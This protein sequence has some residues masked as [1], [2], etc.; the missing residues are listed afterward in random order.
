[1]R[2]SVVWHRVARSPT[3]RRDGE[4]QDLDVRGAVTLADHR[5][6][7]VVEKDPTGD[8]SI[9]VARRGVRADAVTVVGVEHVQRPTVVRHRH[10]QAEDVGHGVGV[11][12]ADRQEARPGGKRKGHPGPQIPG[13]QAVAVARTQPVYPGI[14]SPD[15]HGSVV[16]ERWTR[17]V[18][19][20]SQAPLPAVT[21]VATEV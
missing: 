11:P 18:A 6:A 5:D 12:S 2:S 1:M 10:D 21:V 7:P 20:E 8:E 4:H 19:W 9:V 16:G 3:R 13:P 15:V 14:R 17:R